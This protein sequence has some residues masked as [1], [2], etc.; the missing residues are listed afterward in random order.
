MAASLAARIRRRAA[1][2]LARPGSRA[3][4]LMYHRIDAPPFDPWGLSVSPARFR[5]QLEALAVRG[6]ILPVDELVAAI[7][8]RD[9]QRH[10]AA[11]TFDD[12]YADNLTVAKPILEALG[13]PATVFLTSGAIGSPRKFWW[14]ELGDL[15]FLTRAAT[16]F[17]LG[18]G[19]VRLAGSWGE[20]LEPPGW[21]R[22]WR[23]AQGP[24]DPRTEAYGAIW[25]TL[26]GLAPDERDS[27]MEALRD[28]L[29]PPDLG[30]SG[31][32]AIMTEAM[33]RKLGS[34]L[35]SIGG[36]AR[37]HAPLTGLSPDAM[38]REIA[39]GRDDLAALAGGTAPRGFAYPHGAHDSDVR[40]V[41][42]EAGYAWAVTTRP[43]TAA[44]GE[45][46]YG[47][48][49]LVVADC[50][51]STLLRSIARLGG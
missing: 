17:D 39:G 11:I 14:D 28:R 44:P 1:R 50:T 6:P 37:S 34:H 10:A 31:G 32:A 3:A 13:V 36:H 48:P 5:E 47:L 43:D 42:K 27:A 16:E 8:A 12:G 21:L 2:L 46:R 19:A 22:G 24:R 7:A 15:V 9:L 33:A 18:V 4:I 23:T 30:E 26:Q 41:V 25:R 38:R 20:W 45:D 35:V 49:R 51:A 40:R 29:G